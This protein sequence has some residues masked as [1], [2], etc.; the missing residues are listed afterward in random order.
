MGGAFAP[1]APPLRMGLQPMLS[2]V[3]SLRKT[4]VGKPIYTDRYRVLPLRASF[5]TDSQNIAR[6]IP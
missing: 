5:Y 6:L 3:I 1:F 4:T 2:V